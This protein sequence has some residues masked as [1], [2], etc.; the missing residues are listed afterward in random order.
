MQVTGQLHEHGHEHGQLHVHVQY[1]SQTQ[2]LVLVVVAG[3]APSLVGRNWIKY[4]GLVVV[5]EWRVT[6]FKPTQAHGNAP[7]T[8]QTQ[9]NKVRIQQVCLMLLKYN[10]Y[11][12]QIQ[13]ET[14][15]DPVLKTISTYVSNI[16]Y[17]S[18]LQ[19]HS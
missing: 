5:P 10:R 1:G 2:P 12:L 19:D 3:H 16:R 17:T 9:L 15:R 18:T 7:L 13:T 4:L 8:T 11:Q 14:L 6:Q